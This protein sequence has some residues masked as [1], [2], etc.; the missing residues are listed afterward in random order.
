MEALFHCTAGID[1]HKATFVVTVLVRDEHDRLRHSTRTFSTFPQDLRALA[2]WLD[3]QKVEAVGF[4]STGVFWKPLYKALRADCPN[5][6]FWLLNPLHVKQIPGRKTDVRDS[7]WLAKLVMFGQVHSS[8][9][10]TDLQEQLRH[11]VRYRRSLT[12]QRTA[13]V[14]RLHKLLETEGL[15]LASVMTDVL[16]TSGRAILAALAEGKQTPTQMAQLARGALRKKC[17]LLR[18]AL[19]T[20]LSS[21]SRWLLQ[22]L[23]GQ[24]QALERLR[25]ETDEHLKSLQAPYL[26]A[27]TLLQTVPGVGLQTALTFVAEA[28]AD[29]SRFPSAQHLASWAGL[30]P[31]SNESA[32]KRGKT[33]VRDG[34]KGLRTALVQAA[35]V[36]IRSGESPWGS[37][38]RSLASRR[39]QNVA[40]VGVARKMAEVMFALLRDGVIYDPKKAHQLTPQ[41]EER[42]KVRSVEALEALGYEVQLRPLRKVA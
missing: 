35:W 8:L 9:L 41:Q 5:A 4:E 42:R 14:N 25:E 32:G 7:G 26:S 13:I 18:Q 23:L 28:G 10:P 29:M 27:L 34:N 21:T 33:P 39:G 17:E 40:I 19:D 38:F 36:S 30:V 6:E 12:E 37:W 24:E 16:G 31:S 20:P 3:E 11:L 2:S 22:K 1:V 15:K